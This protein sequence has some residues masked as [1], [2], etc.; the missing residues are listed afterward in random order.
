MLVHM[1][2]ALPPPRA[3]LGVYV[4]D[5]ALVAECLRRLVDVVERELLL[6]ACVVAPAAAPHKTVLIVCQAEDVDRLRMWL[7]SHCELLSSAIVRT[8]G[9]YLGVVICPSAPH[10]M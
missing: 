1:Q 9:I 6:Q 5:V 10:L 4:D 8:D 7:A 2:A 3:V